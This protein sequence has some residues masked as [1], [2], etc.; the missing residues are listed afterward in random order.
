[1]F[2]E[3]RK[4]RNLTQEELAEVLQISTRQV[5]RIENSESIPSLKLLKKIITILNIN[6]NDIIKYIRK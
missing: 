5:Q 1:M 3:Y 2:K 4:K 6:D